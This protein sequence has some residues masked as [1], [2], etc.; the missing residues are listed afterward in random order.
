[1]KFGKAKDH[2]KSLPSLYLRRRMRLMMLAVSLSS[3]VLTTRCRCV[4][5]FSR[6]LIGPPITKL[7]STAS[8]TRPVFIC[9][10]FRG[11]RCTLLSPCE[12]DAACT[13]P[14]ELHLRKDDEND[15]KKT[16]SKSAIVDWLEK[17]RLSFIVFCSFQ[18]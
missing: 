5:L 6:L 12:R 3:A 1:M 17:F 8:Y 13:T 4:S 2:L 16:A 7:D 9:P 15:V 11:S 10:Q 14:P 18:R